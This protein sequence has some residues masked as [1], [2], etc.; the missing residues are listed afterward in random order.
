MVSGAENI[1]FPVK[2][3]VLGE[4]GQFNF[5]LLGGR[6]LGAVSKGVSKQYVQLSVSGS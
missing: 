5:C 1:E 4:T 6:A 2:L 3:P